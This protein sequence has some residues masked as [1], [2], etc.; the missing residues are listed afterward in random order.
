[1]SDEQKHDNGG[2]AYPLPA[3][4]GPQGDWMPPEYGMTLWD[5]YFG[6]A[7]QAA[8][9]TYNDAESA[10]LAARASTIGIEPYALIALDAGGLADAMI[11]ERNRRAGR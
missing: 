9:S 1:M 3:S 11:A 7:M 5:H 2:A 4:E 10:R 8:V 6:L